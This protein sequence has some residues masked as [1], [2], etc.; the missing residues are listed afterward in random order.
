MAYI[1]ANGAN[2]KHVFRLKLTEGDVNV[3][4]NTSPVSF[5]FTIA[6]ISGQTAT[7]SNWGSA[8]TYKVTINGQSYT[9]SIPSYETAGS[10]QTIRSGTQTITHASDGTKTISYSFSVTDGAGQTF[11]CGDASASGSM[12]LTTIPRTSSVTAKGAYIGSNATITINSASSSFTHSLY[13]AIN[14]TRPSASSS[15]W[16]AIALKTSATSYKFTLPTSIY[17]KIPNSM[18]Y[19]GVWVKCITYSGN[20]TIGTAYTSCVA[21]V[22]AALCTPTCSATWSCTDYHTFT[23]STETLI[24]YVSSVTGTVTGTALNSATVSKLQIQMDGGDW[25]DA[26]S[27]ATITSV[28]SGTFNSR[29]IDSRGIIGYGTVK[30]FD[31][32]DYIPLTLSVSASRV[33]PVTDNTVT[34]ALK[35]NWYNGNFQ[36]ANTLS[37]RYRYRETGGTWGSYNYFSAIT[38]G[39]TYSYSI[40]LSNF[41]YLKTY[42]I[43]VIVDDALGRH[44]TSYRKTSTVSISKGLP[45]F[46]WDADDF[47]FNVDVNINGS[48]Y[49]GG[50][51]VVPPLEPYTYA[52]CI[53]TSMKTRNTSSPTTNAD[54]QLPLGSHTVVGDRLTASTSGITVGANVNHVK[55]DAALKLRASSSNGIRYARIGVNGNIVAEASLYMT[56]STTETS[57]VIAPFVYEV[58]EGDVIALYYYTAGG[59]IYGETGTK[60]TYLTV[61]VI[62]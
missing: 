24:K 58:N 33:L 37:S 38:S 47:Q 17:A 18:K 29:A 30:T 11:T 5:T 28:T 40:T 41:D 21:S 12:T 26:G 13:Y 46:D 48:L 51:K 59:A 16:T 14:D 3:T 31:I 50:D 35:G 54:T 7:W 23:G 52:P 45:V 60:K 9:G 42:E 1:S 15:L 43:E 62:D 36:T 57:I 10:T 8:I 22:N 4:A 55:I 34:V 2:N 53:A 39:N 25:I 44:D 32:I 6:N 19:G 56:T 61:E 49:V 27:G 20:T